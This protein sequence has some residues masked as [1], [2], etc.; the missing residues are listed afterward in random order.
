MSV[1]SQINRIKT[2][3]N[4][5]YTAVLEMGGVVSEDMG[6]SNL[7]DSIRTIK[8]GRN[9][10]LIASYVTPGTH[11]FTVPDGVYLI[12]V[13]LIGG[14]E[15][16]KCYNIHMNV[17]SPATSSS[18]NYCVNGGCSGEVVNFIT[19]VLP[20][21]TFQGVV[22]AGGSGKTSVITKS[23]DEK[24]AKTPGESTSFQSFIA[25]GGNEADEY[26]LMCDDVI[27]KLSPSTSPDVV[28]YAPYANEHAKTYDFVNNIFTP[29]ASIYNSDFQS[30][31]DGIIYRSCGGA[32][33]IVKYDSAAKRLGQISKPVTE[34]KG[35]DGFV[36]YKA[37][38]SKNPENNK[39]NDATGYGNGGGSIVSLHYSNTYNS[40]LSLTATAGSGS[41]GAIFI[42]ALQ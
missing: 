39:G 37:L 7:A 22:G 40:G 33:L 19:H 36:V 17:S 16:G 28:L 4:N 31:F 14:G 25:H 13:T 30:W 10:S 42:Y 41:D 12:G 38:T 24:L 5:A 2:N 11:S 9:W 23:G 26:G 8:Q 1:Q 6:I 34:G 20:G 15:S 27:T 35:G 18:L 32:A 21:E 29:R 3:I